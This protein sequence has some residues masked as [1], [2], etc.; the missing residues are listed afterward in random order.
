MALSQVERQ[1]AMAFCSKSKGKT[2]FKEPKKLYF[3]SSMVLTEIDCPE[4]K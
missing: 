3:D 4:A 2:I 1:S